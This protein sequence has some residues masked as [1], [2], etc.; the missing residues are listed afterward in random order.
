MTWVRDVPSVTWWET[1]HNSTGD[2][3]NTALFT[4]VESPLACQTGDV[5]YNGGIPFLGE[6]GFIMTGGLLNLG[7]FVGKND[8]FF[9]LR[10]IAVVYLARPIGTSLI[11]YVS[12]YYY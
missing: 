8:M 10:P 11:R 1:P 12:V 7:K 6:N 5:C 3:K 2:R 4:A 9:F